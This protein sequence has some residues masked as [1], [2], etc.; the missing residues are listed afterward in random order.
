[1]IRYSLKCNRGHSFE[2]WFA[3]AATFESLSEAGQVIC[4]YCGSR[5]VEKALMSPAVVTRNGDAA[6]AVKR[7]EEILAEHLLAWR[8]HI[9]ENA[10]YV[11]V[12]FVNEARAIHEGLKPERAIWGEAYPDEARA[13]LDEGIPIAPLPFIPRKNTN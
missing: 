9:E 7:P 12:E 3:N 1:M 2:S 11:G 4:P 5:E 6:P 10:E 8:R 13:L